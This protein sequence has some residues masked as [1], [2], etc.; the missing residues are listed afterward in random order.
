MPL[1]NMEKRGLM[2]MEEIIGII[3]ATIICLFLFTKI[4]S[5]I[6]GMLFGEQERLQAQ[7]QLDNLIFRLELLDEAGEKAEETYLLLA[8]SKWFL[9]SF[10]KDER[11]PSACFLRNCICIC[12]K[13]GGFMWVGRKVNSDKGG[14]CR[15]IIKDAKLEP[16]EVEI[17]SA[18]LLSVDDFFVIKEIEWKEGEPIELTPANKEALKN[19]NLE[20]EEKGYTEIIE[21]ASKE[22][23]VS[24]ALIKAIMYQESRGNPKVVGSCGEAGL[25]QF[26]PLTARSVGIN[27]IFE[28]ADFG[29]CDDYAREYAN[30][31]KDEIKDKSLDEIK[32]IDERFDPNM[33]IMAAAKHIKDLQEVFK[34]NILAVIAAYN[35]GMGRVKEECP[36][37]EIRTCERLPDTTK[38]YFVY[39]ESYY[40]FFKEV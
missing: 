9:A 2:L 8:P 23:S 29:E 6:S 14:I 36:N 18:L 19:F 35:A 24:A 11:G 31:L 37:L 15:M 1:L 25:M 7:A 20:I 28:D 26:M 34:D 5:A 32:K 21:N 22:Y 13:K 30:R 17:P 38:S 16:E 10:S 12:Q 4:L 40:N 27:L 3:I 33:S 39:V